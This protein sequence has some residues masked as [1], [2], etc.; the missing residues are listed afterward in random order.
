MVFRK[1]GEK[2]ARLISVVNLNR[3]NRFHYFY[4]LIT[5][6]CL[7]KLK[8]IL[9]TLQLCAGY[10]MMFPADSNTCPVYC[11]MWG[12]HSKKN[13]WVMV[14]TDS[15]VHRIQQQSSLARVEA[16]ENLMW[17]FRWVAKIGFIFFY[18]FFFFF[19]IWPGH[20]KNSMVISLLIIYR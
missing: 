17:P 16:K 10:I 20:V 8:A 19:F 4:M 3:L 6:E 13:E 14:Q 7:A 1:V 9:T 2:N 15:K 5:F 11:S 18:L 12:C